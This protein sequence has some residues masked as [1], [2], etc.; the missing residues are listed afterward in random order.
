MA[1]AR[2]TRVGQAQWRRA[3]GAGD[4]L[5]A[6]SAAGI[7]RLPARSARLHADAW[8]A[9]ANSQDI[10]MCS[11]AMCATRFAAGRGDWLRRRETWAK[12]TRCVRRAAISHCSAGTTTRIR[13][14]GMCAT[15][16]WGTR[17]PVVLNATARNRGSVASGCLNSAKTIRCVRDAHADV[18]RSGR[19]LFQQ[20]ITRVLRGPLRDGLIGV[21]NELRRPQVSATL[22]GAGA[23]TCGAI[24]YAVRGLLR[25]PARK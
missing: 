7:L 19:P 25:R 20:R 21:R 6:H 8:R 12:W 4:C 11:T 14:S 3:G 1:E 15:S 13:S 16:I 5:P 24:G 17:R 18:G 23:V 22:L 2:A 9:R 10:A